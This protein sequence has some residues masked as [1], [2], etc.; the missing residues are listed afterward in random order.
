MFVDQGSLENL[1]VRGL[2]K[3]S[4][5]TAMVAKGLAEAAKETRALA[6][7]VEILH[8]LGKVVLALSSLPVNCGKKDGTLSSTPEMRC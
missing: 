8:D 5:V 3:H 4:V 1:D 6:F 2:W 7:T